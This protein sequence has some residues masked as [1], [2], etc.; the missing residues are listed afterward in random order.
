A[1][2]ADDKTYNNS[3][4]YG[5]GCFSD[6][7]L[8]QWWAHVLGLGYVLPRERVRQALAAVCK[9]NWRADLT[10]HKHAQ[11]VFATGTEKGLLNGSW[12]KGGRPE[13]P[14]LYC[15]EVWTGIEYQVAATLLY[16]GMI[17]EAL[18]VVRGARDRYTGNQRN[19]WSEIECGQHYAR[20]MSSYSLLHA[21]AGLVYDA[22]AA[23]LSMA[24]RLMPDNFKAFFTAAEGWGSLVQQCDARAQRNGIEMRYGKIVL[25][26]F[27]VD[28]ARAKTK[29][30]R[31]VM[32]A[33]RQKVKGSA[34][35]A[36][37][38]CVVTFAKPI[39]LEQGDKL[40]VALL[41]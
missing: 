32:D 21:A 2:N 28:L 37:G 7:L 39:T 19:P 13:R 38:R 4:C 8:G 14:I 16:E 10:D 26:E 41:S 20:A 30:A 3:N 11:R 23:R 22:G 18:A 9:Y 33:A 24:P 36:N 17:D 25:K 31:V 29:P 5:P 27:S 34:S 12:P 35:I 1:P 40:G 6:Q 15:D